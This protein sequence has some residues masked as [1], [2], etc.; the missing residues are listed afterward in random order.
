MVICIVKR[1]MENLYF[2]KRKV[3]L[4]WLITSDMEYKD[5]ARLKLDSM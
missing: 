2:F 5:K 3:F 4:N 1:E